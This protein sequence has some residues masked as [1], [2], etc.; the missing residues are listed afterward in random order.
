MEDLALALKSAL[1]IDDIDRLIVGPMMASPS[2]GWISKRGRISQLWQPDMSKK[3][4][5][6]SAHCS[7]LTP[8]SAA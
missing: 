1:P 8:A 5:S 7:M 2:S 6:V 3:T 4:V